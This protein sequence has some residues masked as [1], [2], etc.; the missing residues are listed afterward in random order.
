MAREIGDQPRAIGGVDHLGVKL[1]RIILPRV[2]GDDGIGRATAMR[3]RAETGGKL[4][5]LIAMAHPHL[6]R[7]ALRPEAVEQA[8]AIGN[9]DKRM[10]EFATVAAADITAKLRHH[11]LLAI[12]NA[13]H[14]HAALENGRRHARAVIVEHRRRR[15]GQDHAAR[16]HPCKGFSGSVERRDLAIDACLA[17]TPRDQ[18]CHL[19]AEIDDQ[20]RIGMVDHGVR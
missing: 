11:H 9:I 6:M 5:H 13:E 18:L 7:L 20:D 1:H 4:S 8:A 15:S 2:V 19:A 10:A 12:A 17:D 14:R 3:D 16:L